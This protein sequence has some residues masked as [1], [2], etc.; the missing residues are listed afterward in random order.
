ML[1]L[2][3]IRADLQHIQ[4]DQYA[5]EST[6]EIMREKVVYRFAQGSENLKP[7]ICP[8]VK[9]KPDNSQDDMSLQR[10]CVGPLIFSPTSMQTDL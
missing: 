1:V 3:P 6:Y 7:L 9:V 10:V 5:E 8:A 4:L 2:E